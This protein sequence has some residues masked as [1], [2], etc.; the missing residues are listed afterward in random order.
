MSLPT[1]KQIQ[2]IYMSDINEAKEK[3]RKGFTALNDAG[4]TQR[5]IGQDAGLSQTAVFRII[6]GK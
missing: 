4:V 6:R 2:N 3:R 5:R 1:A